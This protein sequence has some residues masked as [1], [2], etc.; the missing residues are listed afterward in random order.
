MHLTRKQ[1][2]ALA[3]LRRNPGPW[4]HDLTGKEYAALKADGLIEEHPVML[5]ETEAD[6]VAITPRG[7]KAIKHQRMS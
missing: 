2:N 3:R 6:D 5:V 4:Q 1:L 7:L